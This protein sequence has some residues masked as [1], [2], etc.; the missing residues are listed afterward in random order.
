METQKY[1]KQEEN[2]IRRKNG[3]KRKKIEKGK[4]K[5]KQSKWVPTLFDQNFVIIFFLILK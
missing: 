4:E 2:E 3:N 1:Q 5:E